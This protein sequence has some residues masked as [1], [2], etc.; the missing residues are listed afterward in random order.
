MFGSSR[1]IAGNYGPSLF[2]LLQMERL[3][4]GARSGRCDQPLSL[5]QEL[6]CSLYE[7]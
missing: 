6:T 4:N 5:G 7:C 3:T 1:E 2:T